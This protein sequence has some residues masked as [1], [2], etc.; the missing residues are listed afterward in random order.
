MI[1]YR[2]LECWWLLFFRKL[3]SDC[4]PRCFFSVICAKA[5]GKKA[6]L[7]ERHYMGGDCLNVI[8]SHTN[9]NFYSLQWYK[10]IFLQVAVKKALN[11]FE[12]THAY[13]KESYYSSEMRISS[14][15]STFLVC[16]RLSLFQVG[17]F[18]SKAIIRCARAVHEVS[19]SGSKLSACI[20]GVLFFRLVIFAK[21]LM[22]W[23]C[24]FS[25][26]ARSP[27]EICEVSTLACVFS[28]DKSLLFFFSASF[29]S[30]IFSSSSYS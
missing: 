7:I 10:S 24:S 25:Y 2:Q 18:P 15:T 4:L 3:A 16:P 8:V 12:D 23:S 26:C 19:G 6:C 17:C 13:A 9:C 22:A 29:A 28:P 21:R 11:S 30:S 1:E 27:R 20:S 5:L 14:L